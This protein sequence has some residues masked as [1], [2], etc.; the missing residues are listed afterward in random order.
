[1]APE[2]SQLGMGI[3]FSNYADFSNLYNPTQLLPYVTKAIHK[4]YIKVDEEG[5][6]AAAVTGIVIGFTAPAIAFIQANHPFL[7]CIAEK[8]TGAILFL[9]IVNDPSLE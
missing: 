9:G 6:Q 2:L 4:T 7:Y 3:I 1:M 8:Q 5:T